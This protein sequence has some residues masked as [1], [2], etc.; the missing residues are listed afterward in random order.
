MVPQESDRL[1][2]IAVLNDNYEVDGIEV[3]LAPEAPR[4]I[5][6]R[7]D[8]SIELRAQGTEEPQVSFAVFVRQLKHGFY[9]R[10]DE[11]IVAEGSQFLFRESPSTHKAGLLR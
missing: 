2:E 5:G 6:R 8:G 3:A 7:V 11:H 10:A 1:E 9:D 4:E